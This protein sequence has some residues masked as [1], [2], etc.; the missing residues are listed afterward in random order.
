MEKF[1][2][3]NAQC[4]QAVDG[5]PVC[6]AVEQ[7][8]E[9]GIR[10]RVGLD[11]GSTTVKAVVIEAG[12]GRILWR[13]YQR[14]ETRQAEMLLDF[15]HRM[16]REAGVASGNSL[17]CITGSGG[18]ALGNYIGAKFVQ[19]VN[20]VALAVERLH[21]EVNSV[22]ELGGQDAK[23]ILFK[24]DG[25]SGRKKRFSSMNDKC[26]GGTG[27]VIDKINAKLKISSDEL[28][29]QAYK[30]IKVHPVA[31][32]CGVFAETDIN[33]L[34]KQG[35][36]ADELMAS[37]FDAIVLQNL[38]VLTRGN[39]LRPHVLLLG[40][41]NTFIRG[42]REAWQHHIPL[43]WK[44]RKIE[45]PP[46]VAIE[47]LIKTPENALYFAA[48]GAVEFGKDEGPEIGQYL[49]TKRLEHYVLEGRRQQRET[50]CS[51]GLCSSLTELQEFR[52]RY[53]PPE[54]VPAI[55]LPGERVEAFIGIDGGSTS[56]KA[57][58]LSEHGEVLSKA[59]RLSNGNPIQD[60]IEI[61]ANLRLQVEEQGATLDVLGVGTTGYAKDMLQ[62]VLRADVALVETVAHTE[63]ALRFFADP[64][65]IVDVGG[66]DIKLIIL[67][68]GRV[69]DFKLNTQCSAGNGYF[70]QSTAE[71]F[72]IPVERYAEV[73]FKAEAMPVFGYGCAVFL[74]TDIVNF[75]RQGWLAEE[76]LAGLATVLPRNVFLH[77]AKVPNLTALGTRFVLQGGTQKNLAVVKAEVDFLRAIF[78]A[79][80]KEPEIVVHPHCGESGAIGTA[81]EALRVWRKG[82]ATT[83]IGMNAVQKIQYRSTRNDETR[84]NFCKNSCQRTFLDVLSGLEDGNVHL[85]VQTKVELRPEEQRIIIAGC[86]KGAVEDVATMRGIQAQ[87]DE[88]KAANPNLVEVAAREVWQSRQPEMIADLIPTFALTAPARRRRSLM[89]MRTQL[90]IGV[91]R[92]LN[93]YAYAPLFSSY[94]E[95]LGVPAGN[96]VYSD[97]TTGEMYRAGSSRGSIDPCYP[98]KIA[99]AHVHN[100]LFKQHLRKPLHVIFFPMFDVLPSPLI[101]VR[102]TNACPTAS[103]TPET[104]EAAFTK[105]ID[106]F[107]E[108][109]IQYV[110]PLVNLANRKLFARQMFRAWAPILGLSEEENER[111]IKVGY[112]ELE[113]YE[114]TM[115]HRARE[116]LVQLE[117]QHRLGIVMLGRP[118]HHDPGINHEIM[119][120]FQ[121]LGYPIFSQST[122][123]L[124]QD[125]LERLFGEEVRA[126]AFSHPLDISDIWKTAFSASSNHKLWAAKFTARHPS[127]V[128]VEVSSFKCGHDAP[129]YSAIEQIIERSGTPYFSFKDLDENR[130]VSSIKLRV[131]TVDYFLKRYREDLLR[132][133]RKEAEIELQLA[134]YERELREQ[135]VEIV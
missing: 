132:R 86:E 87:L 38:T 57:V 29:H 77:V 81:I 53:S 28:C 51:H 10:F 119:E 73:A 58:L 93:M 118:Y 109:G 128:A 56:T 110:H 4:G 112:E 34:Q 72:G 99:I 63:S 135:A 117:S 101:N 46:D 2:N 22:I 95:S 40:G 25:E 59:Y 90:R 49:G 122:L 35:I 41:P 27:A 123:P 17:I 65:V 13:D 31:G 116:V 1:L 127:L 9:A 36:P 115:R 120:Q 5:Q 32:K 55:F 18:H 60:T 106:L 8:S 6:I 107:A 3:T 80:G 83:F 104:V 52:A 7:R 37:L 108:R 24:D 85:P 19:E 111:A 130:P 62:Q 88:V 14:H 47:E 105:E 134:M 15:L 100:L 103:I 50:S 76:I 102:A 67:H 16:E 133:K 126:G 89:K 12:S 124:D 69:K 79:A 78:R 61:L 121:K 30:G 129:I 74:Q 131:E 66:Q 42:M 113:K 96:I 20:A 114:S 44:E 21:P 45:L 94:L 23:I 84:C 125:L 92:V 98:S 91:P 39:T 43:L 48:L 71:G 68:N 11:V 82:H 70:L 54:F 64:Q 75:Q 26:A 33:G 97:F